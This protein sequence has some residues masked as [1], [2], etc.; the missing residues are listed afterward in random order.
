MVARRQATSSSAVITTPTST[1]TT[2][3]TT[4]PTS[5][6]A[7]TSTP[8]ESTPTTTPSYDTTPGTTPTSSPLA[9]A[10][11]TPPQ[12]TQVPTTVIIEVTTSYSSTDAAGS[13]IVIATTVPTTLPTTAIVSTQSSA[14]SS[15]PTAA[16]VGGV[17]GGVAFLLAV[18]LLFYCLRRRSNK[19]EFDGIFDPDR[20]VRQSGGGTLPQVDL[21]DE[22]NNITPFNAYAPDA[23]QGAGQSQYNPYAHDA[24]QGMKQYGQPAYVSGGPGS[25]GTASTNVQY[26]QSVSPPPPSS[27]SR[28]SV[29]QSYYHGSGG[30]SPQHSVSGRP[31]PGAGGLPQQPFSMYGTAPAD[32]HTPR[33]GSSPPASTVPSASVSSRSAK[34]REAIGG[35]GGPYGLG[36]ATQHEV[37]EG[38]SVRGSI[39]SDPTPTQAGPAPAPA[40]APTPGGGAGVVVHQDAGRAPDT[41]EPP[42]EIPPSYDSI[43]Q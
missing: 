10:T 27:P 4:T 5:T 30:H 2:T 13:I 28:Y 3:H 42:Q 16:I 38:S 14:S 9:S 32:W 1:S 39:A 23:G 17:V 15:P 8:S 18:A 7:S 24:G 36:L 6:P 35:R 40:P 41:E 34:E 21:V 12:S 26:Q 29:D 37:P 20:V 19:D 43:R 33:P 22:S 31:P 11:S 25:I